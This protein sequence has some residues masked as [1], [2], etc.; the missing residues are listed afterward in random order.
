MRHGPRPRTGLGVV[1]VLPDLWALPAA[2]RLIRLGAVSGWAVWPRLVGVSLIL[3]L[4]V[5]AVASWSG[6]P[7]WRC[8]R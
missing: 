3:V 5:V 4:G 2:L 8:A 6:C 7:P 1:G